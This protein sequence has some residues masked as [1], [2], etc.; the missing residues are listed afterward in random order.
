MEK[1][2]LPG[3]AAKI[4]GCGAE[5]IRVLERTGKLKAAIKTGSGVRLFAREDIDRLV[6]QRK[7]RDLK[8]T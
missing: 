5:N 7:Q 8:R 2:L 6:Q 1:F 4:V 3:E